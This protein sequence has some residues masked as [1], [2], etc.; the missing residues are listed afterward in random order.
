MNTEK[1][2]IALPEEFVGIGEVR[3]FKFT[4]LEVG[5]CAFLYQVQG[6]TDEGQP[7][8]IWYEVFKA[9]SNPV[10]IDFEKRI[11]SE[12]EFKMAYPKAN[13]FGVWAWSFNDEQ[14]AWDK[15]DDLDLF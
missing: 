1:K 13:A 15:F 7:G 4:L 11:Y 2:Y 8:K 5:D 9:K 12:T 3:G 14:K 6:M 10:C